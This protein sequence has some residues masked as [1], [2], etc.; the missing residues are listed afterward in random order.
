MKRKRQYQSQKKQAKK[1]K[2]EKTTA[3]PSIQ[4]SII[5]NNPLNVKKSLQEGLSADAKMPVSKIWAKMEETYLSNS[6]YF[7]NK[8][9][10][11]SLLTAA[12]ELYLAEVSEEI[13]I[14]RLKIIE[15]LSKNLP[16]N[17]ILQ[18]R[19]WSYDE[20]TLRRPLTLAIF[21][22]D[23]VLTTTLLNSAKNLSTAKNDIYSAIFLAMMEHNL[24]NRAKIIAIIDFL[25][26]KLPLTVKEIPADQRTLTA[27]AIIWVNTSIALYER[28]TNW[29]TPTSLI[30]TLI[31]LG[32]NFDI[33][34]K[35]YTWTSPPKIQIVSNTLIRIK[36]KIFDELAKTDSKGED[37]KPLSVNQNLLIAAKR[38]RK[39][40]VAFLGPTI[41]SWTRSGFNR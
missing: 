12:V 25:L 21:A 30:V 2:A 4:D 35:Y 8:N 27:A 14:S 31:K 29:Y 17:A 7:R 41:N 19:C 33:I 5:D 13:Q 37:K 40:E 18:R 11:I 26:S 20:K 36:Q 6:H 9:E 38:P 1:L 16:G 3:I 15:L 34:I 28:Y 23:L 24:H 32:T 39:T 22:N 10:S